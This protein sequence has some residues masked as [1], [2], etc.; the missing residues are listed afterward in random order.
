M[1]YSYIYHNPVVTPRAATSKSGEGSGRSRSGKVD[2]ATYRKTGTTVPG[3]AKS[4]S[5]SDCDTAGDDTLRTE[6]DKGISLPTNSRN[7][8]AASLWLRNRKENIETCNEENPAKHPVPPSNSTL[9]STSS[10][11][12]PSVKG[13]KY[14]SALKP[15]FASKVTDSTITSPEISQTDTTSVSTNETI[16]DNVNKQSAYY[17]PPNPIGSKIVRQCEHCKVLFTSF[18]KCM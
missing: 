4:V 12:N 18:H 10:R 14:V 1:S 11:Y 5:M 13:P 8:G 9:G 17:R 16:L 3:K 2:D 15:K 6:S 7:A